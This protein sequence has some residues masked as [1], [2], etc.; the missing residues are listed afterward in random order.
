MI[1]IAVCILIPTR[2]YSFCKHADIT[3]YKF[4]SALEDFGDVSKSENIIKQVDITI[5]EYIERYVDI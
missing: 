5:Y 1:T 3:K 4:T 2:V